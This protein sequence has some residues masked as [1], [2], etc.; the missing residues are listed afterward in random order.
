VNLLLDTHVFLWWAL[1]D[2]S[3]LGRARDL[4]SD[5]RTRVSVS[6]ASVWEITIKKA[7]GKLRAPDDVRARLQADRFLPLAL[8][9]DHA[10]AVADLPAHHHDPFDRLLIAQARVERLTL[11]TADRQITRYDVD[12]LLI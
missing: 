5:G 11:V 12:H 8:S 9:V 2:R 3:A 6:S 10:L 4:I 1:D 7:L